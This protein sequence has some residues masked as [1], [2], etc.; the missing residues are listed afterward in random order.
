MKS[1]LR[2]VVYELVDLMALRRGI[3]RTYGEHEV[4]FPPRYA[5][6]YPADYEPALFRFLKQNLKAGDTYWDCGAHFGLFS[7]VASRLVGPNGLVL[8]FEPTPSVR[9]VLAKVVSM[10]EVCNVIVRPEA[11]S[12]RTG[13][14]VFYV[15]GSETSNANS[16]IKQARHSRGITIHTS[17]IDDIAS[18]LS[19][20]AD[21]MKI[22]VEGA[23]FALLKGARGVIEAYKPIL[24]LSLHPTAI[25][26]SGAT[27]GEVF[28]LLEEFRYRVIWRGQPVNRRSFSK[29]TDL[30]DVECF[31]TERNR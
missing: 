13:E 1:V 14:T 4:R 12:D 10:N 9:E 11:L 7:I 27:L 2:T 21:L 31:P 25:A 8:A 20:R 17:T 3:S 18:K 19:V 15:T 24:F 5:R 23:E 26:D 30:F 22:D 29:Q 28:D 16:L 6:Y